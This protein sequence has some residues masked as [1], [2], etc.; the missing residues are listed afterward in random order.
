MTYAGDLFAWYMGDLTADVYFCPERQGT[1][2][3]G[4]YV[5]DA[6]AIGNSNYSIPTNQTSGLGQEMLHYLTAGQAPIL[7]SVVTAQKTALLGIVARRTDIATQLRLFRAGK[8]PS[9]TTVLS[10]MSQYGAYDGEICWRYA[11]AFANLWKSLSA[12]Q[13]TTLLNR[14][15][16]VLGALAYPSAAFLFSSPIAMPVI[17]NTDF[18]F[19]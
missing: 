16:A 10:L 4:F 7:T 9:M 1:Y 6:P 2:F 13:R 17:P 15:K 5:K 3:G 8:T 19:A 18:L 11:T 12:A 14:R